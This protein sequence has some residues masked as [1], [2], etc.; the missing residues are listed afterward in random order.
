MSEQ[1]DLLERPPRVVEFKLAI[2]P[3]AW[4]APLRSKSGGMFSP[5][6]YA[7]WMRSARALAHIQ[8]R[9]I[10]VSFYRGPIK[11]DFVF[12]IFSKSHLYS[13]R[14]IQ[15]S[16]RS[17]YLKA[18]E[19]AIKGIIIADDCQIDDGNTKKVWTNSAT[20]EGIYI[21]LTL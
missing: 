14:H 9:A 11:A 19:D 12:K 4:T 6:E 20:D 13:E 21:T 17:N 7:D 8:S 2:R 10:G 18:A 1:A 3:K 16:D 5:R 15:K